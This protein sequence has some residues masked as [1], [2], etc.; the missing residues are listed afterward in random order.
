MFINSTASLG[1]RVCL[2]LVP[3]VTALDPTATQS[4]DFAGLVD[5]PLSGRYL[6]AKRCT[7]ADC[8]EPTRG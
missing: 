8:I 2:I 5:C 6:K 1:T 7:P 3:L 4:G